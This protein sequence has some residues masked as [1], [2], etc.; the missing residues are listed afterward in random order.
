MS[1]A[2]SWD[3]LSTCSVGPSD[4]RDPA[5]I[6][7]IVPMDTPR[8]SR[9]SSISLTCDMKTKHSHVVDSPSEF[10]SVFLPSLTLYV[11]AKILLFSD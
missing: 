6:F 4:V 11:M 2:L 7:R 8:K 5:L 9:A 10:G 3:L 1:G